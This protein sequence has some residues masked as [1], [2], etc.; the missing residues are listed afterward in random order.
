M[1]N[2]GRRKTL[3]I[4]GFIFIFAALL[5]Q[6]MNFW[7]ILISRLFSGFGCGISLAVTSRIIEEYVPLAMYS[8]ASPFNIFMG[9]LGSFLALISAVILPPMNAPDQEY[10]DTESWRIIFGMSF[11]WVGVGLFGYFVLVR[12]DT[13]KFYLSKG[14]EEYAIKSIKNI[15]NTEGS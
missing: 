6:V 12:L 14:S 11:V 5:T 7:M 10:M 2:K 1:M 15:Y 13:P 8:T 4:V 3:I 9:Q